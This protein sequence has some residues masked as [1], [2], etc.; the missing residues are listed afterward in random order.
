MYLYAEKHEYET[1]EKIAKVL[2]NTKD[3]N[4]EAYDFDVE[5]MAIDESYPSRNGGI[6]YGVSTRESTRT[7][8]EWYGYF[9]RIGDKVDSDE[10]IQLFVSH[11]YSESKDRFKL[12]MANPY[13]IMPRAEQ[14]KLN[15]LETTRPHDES[16]PMG[17]ATMDAYRPINPSDETSDK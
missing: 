10:A 3:E 12:L 14:T 17:K 8:K 13:R 16:N 6:V 4:G 5:F 15:I 1:I 11:G 9:V 2:E 7:S